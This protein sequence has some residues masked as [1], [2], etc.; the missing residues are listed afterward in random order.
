[1]HGLSVSLSVTIVS[2]AKMAEAIDR[3]TLWG[4]DAGGHGNHVLDEG[5]NPPWK[6][7]ILRGKGASHCKVQRIPSVCHG[8][9]A[10]C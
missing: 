8:D 1:M 3:D 5:A 6:G 2:P 4:A 9:A 7:A 10:C